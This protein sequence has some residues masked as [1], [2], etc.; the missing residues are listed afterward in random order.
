M[1]TE[2]DDKLKSLFARAEEAPADDPFVSE[3]VKRIHALQR[4]DTILQYS[5]I[6]LVLLLLIFFSAD[7]INAVNWA[8]I[9]VGTLL[10]NI[11]SIFTDTIPFFPET[12][13]RQEQ[14]FRVVS[15][16]EI[17]A[18]VVSGVVAAIV[19]VV[20]LAPEIFH[21]PSN[22]RTRPSC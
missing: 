11:S 3:T 2:F 20:S 6:A 14:Q 7:I 13:M 19:M 5:G 8:S 4:R 16:Q 15:I 21:R 17:V 9:K 10:T 1:Q 12:S 22:G 18:Y